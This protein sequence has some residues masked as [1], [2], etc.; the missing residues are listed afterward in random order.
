MSVVEANPFAP[1]EPGRVLP[2]PERRVRAPRRPPRPVP[3]RLPRPTMPEAASVA[4]T[5]MLLVAALAGWALL[6]LFVLGGLSQ[7]RAQQVLHAE[8]RQQLAAETAPT[9]G[10]ITPGDPVALLVIPTLGVRQVV[11]EG[12]ASGD[13]TAGPGHRRDTA[14]PGQAGVSLVYGRSAAYGAPFRSVA[15]LRAGDGLQ[16]TTG[17]GEFV[18]RVDGVRR[19]GDP[20]PAAL[21]A[22]AARITLVT[23][24]GDGPLAS[25]TPVRTVYVDAMLVGEAA[26][27]PGGRPAGV[28]DA[29]K[30]LAA[31][32]SVLPQLALCL[33][34]LLL[35][36]AATAVA[37]RRL[38]G[39]A[40]WPVAAG[41]V[42]ALAWASTDAAA[43]LLPNLL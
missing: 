15:L 4:Y 23:S 34:G 33:Q 21:D 30:A 26:T 2:P 41:I 9:G 1:P 36:V 3:P 16:V 37:L 38:P 13:L 29:E 14:L 19:A 8:L 5:A 22:G 18:Y 12:T 35:A 25:I 42:V 20:L 24:E 11:V 27:G 6:Q 10:S 7:T 28:P 32:R 31:D 40:V 17:Q 39:R 43:Q